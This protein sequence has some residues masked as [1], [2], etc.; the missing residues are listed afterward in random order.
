[1]SSDNDE[2]V[3]AEILDA[4]AGRS[5]LVSGAEYLE[6]RPD[7]RALLDAADLAWEA[8]QEPPPLPEDP[9]AAMLGLVPDPEI[10]LDGKALAAARKRAGLSVSGLAAKMADRGWDVTSRDVFGWESNKNAPQ[11]PAVINALASITGAD[12]D[13]LRR[14][15][16]EDP[17]R[18]RLA[19]VVA[20]SAF[21]SLAERWARLQ[22]TS[23]SLA[24]SALESRMV[25]AVHRGT[26]PEPD[27]LLETLE[28]MVAAVEEPEG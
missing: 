6:G 23:I 13:R 5:A 8:E 14:R 25:A 26:P 21:K 3:I 24:T 16:G 2:D 10:A 17:E 1:M 19:A 27:V 9:V 22:G 11:V 7:L 28:T 20:S 15:L 12:P 4:R 18:A